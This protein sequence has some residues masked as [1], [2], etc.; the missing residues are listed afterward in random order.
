MVLN[1]VGHFNAKDWTG[2][3]RL[4]PVQSFA[5]E[6][7]N[8]PKPRGTLQCKGLDRFQSAE[9]GRTDEISSNKLKN[10]YFALNKRF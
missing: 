3:S 4:K 10:A 8:G 5:L 6:C 9:M 2:F 1:L 7:P